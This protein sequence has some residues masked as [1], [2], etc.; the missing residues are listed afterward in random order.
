MGLRLPFIPVRFRPLQNYVGISI[1]SAILHF[2]AFLLLLL[3]GLSLTII[4]P[5][6]LI[7]V[8]STIVNQP[9]TSIAT[10]LRFGVWGVCANSVF[11]LPTAFSNHGEC[12]GPALGYDIPIEYIK[13]VG[14]DVNIGLILLK[15]LQT[16]L[17][18]HLVAAVLS[19]L[20]LLV[21]LFIASQTAAVAGLALSVAT[22][23]VTNA[24]FIVDLALVIVARNKV[25]VITTTLAVDLGNGVWMVFTAVLCTV[26]GVVLLSVRVCYC[27]GIR[28]V[29]GDIDEKFELPSRQVQI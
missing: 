22:G 25:K 15:G 5:I 26:A 11:N 9:P 16:L 19:F 8:H 10:Q 12:I 3:V 2:T 24:V 14:L 6:F 17:V 4:K 13:N 29:S 23:L 7:L 18:L 28:R 20:A 1:A 27:C 21:S